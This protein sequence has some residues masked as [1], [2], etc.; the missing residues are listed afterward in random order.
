MIGK[1]MR[2]DSYSNDCFSFATS[3]F[4]ER[5]SDLFCHRSHHTGAIFDTIG[6]DTHE[7]QDLASAYISE[8]Y[9]LE[10]EMQSL[11]MKR[12]AAI[13]AVCKC[14]NE[15][16]MCQLTKSFAKDIVIDYRENGF[17]G[18]T[19]KEFMRL[20]EERFFNEDE[21]KDS[22][23][24]K[25]ECL[26]IDYQEMYSNF[27]STGIELQ[28]KDNKSKKTFALVLPVKDNVN[29]NAANFEDRHLG[30]YLILGD[31][32][33]VLKNYDAGK[34]S[35]RRETDENGEIVDYFE[36]VPD[37][38]VE[39][40]RK[41]ISATWSALSAASAIKTFLT[42]NKLDKEDVVNWRSFRFGPR[43]W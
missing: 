42:S 21:S 3:S 2:Y 27:E 10:E 41:C 39:V 1:E 15:S 31:V 43:S 19:V 17:A 34:M 7:A 8:V 29:F 16:V 33:V 20:V 9:K 23:F 18:K 28:F 25:I 4:R 36:K 26:R 38:R 6:D 32:E 12:D 5:E 14:K 30:K 37:S 24:D 13:L 11:K 40:Q 22:I 35:H